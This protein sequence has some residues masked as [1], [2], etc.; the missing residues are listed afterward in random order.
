MMASR[1]TMKGEGRGGRR[2]L[3]VESDQFLH[4]DVLRFLSATGIMVFHFRTHFFA[5]PASDAR[6]DAISLCVDLFFFISGFIIT[7]FYGKVSGVGGYRR[8]IRKRLARLYPLHALTALLFVAIGMAHALR[9]IPLR[10]PEQFDFR[11]LPANMLLLH[12]AGICHNLSFNPVSWSISAEMILYAIFP[13]ILVLRRAGPLTLLAATVGVLALIMIALNSLSPR[14]WTKWTYDYGVIRALPSFMLGMFC[15][16]IRARLGKLPHAATLMWGL[17]ALFCVA[18]ACSAPR[19]VL[20]AILYA[21]AMAGIAADQQTDASGLV[22][23]IAPLGRLTYSLYMVHP[24]VDMTLISFAGMKVLKLT[25]TA[26][27]VWIGLC[28]LLTFPLAWLSFRFVEDPLRVRFSGT[29]APR[30]PP[31]LI[32]P[33]TAGE[34]V[35]SL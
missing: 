27:Q 11:C 34:G 23:A 13:L 25:G 22:R 4:F 21:V 3:S 10:Q 6:L 5:H 9:I 2:W 35:S 8:F 24:V 32:R 16:E 26:L 18:T 29:P 28:F 19:P 1:G 12:A 17:V 20:L 15:Y 31:P 33:V 30:K 7:A 14:E